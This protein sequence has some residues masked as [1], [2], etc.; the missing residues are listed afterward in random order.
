MK[1]IIHDYG[2]VVDVLKVQRNHELLFCRL[3]CANFLQVVNLTSFLQ[4]GV[5][6]L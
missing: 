2:V 6:Y 5:F 3:P 4:M 1:Y